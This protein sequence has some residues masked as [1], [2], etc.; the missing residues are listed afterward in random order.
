MRP[1]RNTI[2]R[3]LL[4]LGIFVA[5]VVAA[6]WVR[7]DFAFDWDWFHRMVVHLPFVVAAECVAMLVFRANQGAWRF[8]SISDVWRISLAI[9]VAQV[10]FVFERIF[11]D[12][13]ALPWGIIVI[14]LCLAVLGCIGIRVVR[15]MKYEADLRRQGKNTIAHSA[16]KTLL[17]GNGAICKQMM[18]SIRIHAELAIEVMGILSENPEDQNRRIDNVPVLGKPDQ[19]KEIAKTHHFD[20]AVILQSTE[21]PDQ[22]RKILDD[23][24]EI[25]VKTRIVPG[26]DNILSGAVDVKQMREISVEDLLHRDPIH[27]E[28]EEISKFLQGRRI[29]VTGAGGSI[30][31]EICRQVLAFQP[32]SLVLLERCELF[33]YEIERELK[34]KA[35]ETRIIPRLADICDLDRMDEV[36]VECRPE[37]VFHAA[38]YKHVPM[39][40][41][42]PGE[43]IRNNVEGTATVANCA[44]KH[45]VD[46]FVMIST[47]KAVNPTSIMGTSKRIAEL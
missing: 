14:N 31:S 6:F 44:V 26:M 40:E 17:I 8:V 3:Y 30:G 36:M 34:S 35:G 16:D 2:A 32:E 23:C 42:N 15:R 7:L 12:F 41:Y 1:N 45:G 37:V 9:L 39:L 5:A 10:P 29:M 18:A 38:A 22:L 13:G 11:R 4:D 47:D 28:K 43:S 19:L 27:L 21:N 20:Q 46:A 33:L 24:A 25:S